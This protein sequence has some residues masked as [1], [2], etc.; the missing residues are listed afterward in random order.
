M[1]TAALAAPVVLATPASAATWDHSMSTN[2]SD[3]GGRVQFRVDG[4]RFRLCDIE[5]DGWKVNLRIWDEYDAVVDESSVGTNGN[6]V[7]R[8]ATEFG[9]RSLRDG[10][11]YTFEIWLSKSGTSYAYADEA[12]WKA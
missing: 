12:T 9:V 7:E 3:P 2:D 11:Y 6:C 8:V 5:A 1:T 10:R 4:D